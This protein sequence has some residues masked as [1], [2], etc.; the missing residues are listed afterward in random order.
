MSPVPASPSLVLVVPGALPP[1]AI[2]SELAKQ[3]SADPS[4]APTLLRWLR[5]TAADV[6]E[7]AVEDPKATPAEAWWLHQAGFVA[8]AGAP[9]G[10]GLAALLAPPNGATPA[11]AATPIWIAELAHIQ[12]GRDGLVLTDTNALDITAEESR[13]LLAT[14]QPLFDADG[15]TVTY[16]A[17]RRWQ[18]SL[19]EGLKPFAATP[20][21]VMGGDL[22]D[23]WPKGLPARPWRRLANDIQMSWH[24]HPVND[25]REARGEPIVNGVWLH[26]GAPAWTPAWRTAAPRHLIGDPPWFQGLAERASIA[27]SGT[28]TP[29]SQL[30]ADTAVLLDALEIPC[31]AQAWGDWLV[32]L[33]KM[34]ADWFAPL[35]AALLAGTYSHIDLVIP[36]IDRTITLRVSPRAKLLRWLPQPKQEWTRWWLPPEY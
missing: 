36:N 4:P 25:A 34:D 7:P 35:D 17:P 3:L 8:P 1:G 12:L 22:N 30:R 23:Y 31:R 10:A 33:K 27:W 16:L 2:A 5:T 21:T 26:G 28:S 32:A 15:F 13:A 9:L 19:P 29:V 11:N 14:V 24:D 18:V 6:A 20:A